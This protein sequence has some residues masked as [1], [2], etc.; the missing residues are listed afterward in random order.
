MLL[1]IIAALA[2]ALLVE[3]WRR[4]L[5]DRVVAVAV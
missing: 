2:S 4:V 5:S 1:V 3:R